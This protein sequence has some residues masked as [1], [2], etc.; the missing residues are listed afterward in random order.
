MVLELQPGAL[1]GVSGIVRYPAYF[2]DVWDFELIS[3][4]DLASIL[5]EMYPVLMEIVQ[6]VNEQLKTKLSA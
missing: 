2:D 3:R 5:E 4:H 6:P 1:M